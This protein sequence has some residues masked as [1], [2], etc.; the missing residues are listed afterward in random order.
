M[1]L[2][3]ATL[4][5]SGCASRWSDACDRWELSKEYPE[6][7]WGTVEKHLIY[8]CTSYSKVP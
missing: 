4:L 7:V 6:L 1:K 3:L 2:I 8:V 5:L